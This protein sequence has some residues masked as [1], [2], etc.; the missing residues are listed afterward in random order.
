[1]LRSIHLSVC[2]QYGI[3]KNKHIRK[4]SVQ[5]VIVTEHVE[6]RVDTRVRTNVQV[7]YNRPDIVVYDK[8]RS[9]ITIIEVGIT[10]Q[11]RLHTVETE[12][13]RKYDLLANELGLIY[14][15]STRIIPYV[16]TWDGIVTR[17]HNRYAK[18]L[19]ITS[20]IHAY[21][22]SRVLRKTLECVSFDRRRGAEDIDGE[23]MGD[24]AVE[25][26]LLVGSKPTVDPERAT[27]AN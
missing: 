3:T 10:S 25:G 26:G 24:M 2:R 4:H 12:K 7:Q 21:I 22:Q 19:G 13:K 18:L 15:S 5:Q 8:K 14:K 6:I 1:M 27:V 20:T 16:M 11:D 23:P 9:E 17:Y